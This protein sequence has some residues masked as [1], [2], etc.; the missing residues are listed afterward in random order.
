MAIDT[1][2][3]PL[4]SHPVQAKAVVFQLGCSKAFAAYRNA[5]WRVLAALAHPEQ[6]I[7]GEPTLLLC[8]YSELRGFNNAVTGTV[9]L[10]STT[11]SHLS[12]H[13]SSVRFPAGRNDVFRPNGLRYEYFDTLTKAWPGRQYQKRT[14]AHPCQMLIPENS[15]F[16]SL[17]LSTDLALRLKAQLPMESYPA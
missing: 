13:Y 17:Q 11:K 14:F 12:T 16:S 3:H 10:A 2:E 8:D 1:H 4:P 6:M 15:P 9:S 7:S 5:T